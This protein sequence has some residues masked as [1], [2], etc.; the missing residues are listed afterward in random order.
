MALA[1]ALADDDRRM[2]VKRKRRKR[3]GRMFKSNCK[4]QRRVGAD[5]RGGI[6]GRR[7]DGGGGGVEGRILSTTTNE[8]NDITQGRG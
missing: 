1:L 2:N 8:P 6:R 3:T 7:F 4:A 5:S